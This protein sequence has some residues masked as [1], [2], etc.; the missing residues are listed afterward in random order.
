MVSAAIRSAIADSGRLP[1]ATFMELA[2][3]SGGGYYSGRR[4]PVGFEGADFYTNVSLSRA[5][6][7][8]LASW[9]ESLSG[10]VDGDFTLVE[11]GAHDGRLMADILA[12]LP[13]GFQP[14]VYVVEPLAMLRAAQA[15]ML[16]D[17]PHR[18]RWVD[19]LNNLPPFSGLFF[20]NELLDALP[21]HVVRSTGCRWEEMFVVEEADGLLGWEAHTPTE[22]VAREL[23]HFPLRP[24][25][26]TTEV[27]PAAR[28]WLEEVASR[29]EHGYILTVDYGGTR[30]WLL[31]PIRT[32]GTL[33]CYHRHV[34]DANPLEN[35]G[36]KDI[37]AHVD[38]TALIETAAA[39]G[40]EVHTFTDQHHFLIEAA[41]PLLAH[42]E[43]QA[44]HPLLR[45]LI[46]LLHPEWMGRR[47]H[48]LSLARTKPSDTDRLS[49]TTPPP[50]GRSDPGMPPA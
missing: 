32:E 16:S 49:P 33:S 3:Y 35:P 30:E 12:A 22:E 27:R 11:Q 26:Y 40:L 47:F 21:F 7:A 37:T 41:R 10:Q 38:F 24:T 8:T 39:C 34:R 23:G 36:Q 2:L 45:G 19:S 29:L 28:R 44:S 18:V 17:F 13:D 1:F 43:G 25:G 6:G 46:P 31:D 4:N 9:A 50:R 14:Q 42:L 15:E 48:A 20:S 5:Y